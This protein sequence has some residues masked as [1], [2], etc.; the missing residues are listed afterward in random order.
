MSACFPRGLTAAVAVLLLAL[1]F[2]VTGCATKPNTISVH[3]LVFD[4]PTL[5]V[6]VGT[7]V[8]WVNNDETAHMIRTDDFGTQGKSQVGQFTSD[9]LNPGES[10]S[11]TFDAAGTFGYG[12][13]LQNY[14]SATIVVK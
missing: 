8:T 2:A 13:P 12:D 11:H 3:D 7:T 5:T 14:M 1:A 10:F 4:P 6:G 9:P